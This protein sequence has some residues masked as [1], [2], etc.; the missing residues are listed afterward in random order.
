MAV[1][2]TM[3]HLIK[4][5][6]TLI[7]DHEEDT[8]GAYFTDQD[9]QDRLDLNRRNLYREPLIGS[10]T[11]AAGGTTEYHDYHST[12]PF[13]ESSTILQD[14]QGTPLTPDESDFLTGYWHFDTDTELYCLYL[15]GR[16]YDV[17]GTCAGLLIN[18]VSRLRK[19]FNFT[20]DGLT[21]QRITQVRDL[22][23][24][25]EMYRRMSWA[26]GNA[27]QVKLVRKDITG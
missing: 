11:L 20:A 26:S 17:Y 4:Y 7:D 22:Q 14:A 10:E 6:R 16:R 8:D 24:Q 15:T 18:L 9:I 27:T 3:D 12:W 21:I 13:W 23:E 25:A 19:E 1:R 2:I 5:V